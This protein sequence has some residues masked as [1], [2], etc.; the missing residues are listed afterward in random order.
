MTIVNFW[1]ITYD[2]LE[3]DFIENTLSFFQIPD[4]LAKLIM[5]MVR[6]TK[7]NVTGN[8]I[9]L[10]EFVPSRGIWQGGPLSPYLLFYTLNGS[11]SC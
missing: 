3:W 1:L 4:H 10:L 11:L 7:F 5:N 8:G 2:T 6:S 9:N